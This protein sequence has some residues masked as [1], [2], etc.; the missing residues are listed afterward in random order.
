[1]KD[2]SF[3]KVHLDTASLEV[4]KEKFSNIT[5]PLSRCVIVRAFNDMAKGKKCDSS[6]FI[7]LASL[8][9][10]EESDVI[11][12]LMAEEH[13]QLHLRHGECLP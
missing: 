3:V 1:M 5:E 11:F 6:Y 12:G 8:I 7:N 2:L 9:F 10:R 4:F 13:L